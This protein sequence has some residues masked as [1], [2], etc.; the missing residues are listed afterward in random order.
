[1]KSAVNLWK[2]LAFLKGIFRLEIFIIP[3]AWNEKVKVISKSI[4]VPINC[5]RSCTRKGVSGSRRSGWGDE[6]VPQC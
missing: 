1:M 3:V 5:H 4:I 2:K 6:Q